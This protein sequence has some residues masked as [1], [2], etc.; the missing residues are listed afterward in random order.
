MRRHK[1]KE[2]R[3]GWVGVGWV[4]SRTAQTPGVTTVLLADKDDTENAT[5]AKLKTSDNCGFLGRHGR[6][7]HLGKTN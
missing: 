4:R 5:L 3:Q 2:E 1:I 7:A 6:A